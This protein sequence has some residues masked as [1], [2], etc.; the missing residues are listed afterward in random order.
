MTTRI[1]MKGGRL[2]SFVGGLFIGGAI[3]Y[4][5]GQLNQCDRIVVQ[6]DNSNIVVKSDEHGINGTKT[7]ASWKG[8]S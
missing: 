7:S 4:H 2:L 6:S 5:I 3:F 1:A 8:G